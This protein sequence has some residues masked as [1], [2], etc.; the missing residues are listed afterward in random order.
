MM[1][2]DQWLSIAGRRIIGRASHDAHLPE[3]MGRRPS[4]EDDRT[5]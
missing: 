1:A 5:E 3:A 2:V 4:S